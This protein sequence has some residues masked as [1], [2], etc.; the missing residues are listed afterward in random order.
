MLESDWKATRDQIIAEITDKAPLIAHAY[1][2]LG[3]A[4]SERGQRPTVTDLSVAC[5]IW[6][7]MIVGGVEERM[8]E[9]RD[10]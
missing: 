2:E 4:M 8:K 7:D 6:V 3:K 9:A 1:V 5:S 10:E